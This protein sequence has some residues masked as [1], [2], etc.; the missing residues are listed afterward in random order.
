MGKTTDKLQKTAKNGI[1][2]S[3]ALLITL[4]TNKKYN[5]ISK[6]TNRLRSESF[7]LYNDIILLDSS[8]I[9]SV[10]Y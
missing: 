1:I 7:F 4:E 8:L 9:Q 10:R 6:L 3:N 5:K 2:I